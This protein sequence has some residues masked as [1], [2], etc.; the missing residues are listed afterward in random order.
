ME[1]KRC[2]NFS[3]EEIDNLIEIINKYKYIIEN[4]KT[5]H[6]SSKKKEDTWTKITNEFNFQAKISRNKASLRKKYE[7]L[8]RNLKVRT[9]IEKQKMCKTASGSST[10]VENGR[11]LSA[12]TP[13]EINELNSF[14]DNDCSGEDLRTKWAEKK[15]NLEI[16]MMTAEHNNRMK[17]HALEIQIMETERKDRKK[18]NQLKMEKLQLEIDA[19][20]SKEV[21]K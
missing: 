16:E 1:G 15:H 3:A 20:R 21:I 12:V 17:K 13:N 7:N 5:D 11:L 10:K 14:Y 8:K 19:L 4:K 6:V 9:S 18:I 2:S